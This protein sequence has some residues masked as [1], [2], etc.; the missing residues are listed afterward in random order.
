[1]ILTWIPN[2]TLRKNTRSIENSPN[3][4]HGT[5][6]KSSPRRTP[7]QEFS[8]PDNSVV[9][10]TTCMTDLSPL[11]S[12][13]S[14]CSD[15]GERNAQNAACKKMSID[16]TAD[17]LGSKEG[18][19]EG[20][21]PDDENVRK[22]SGTSNGSRFDSGVASVG[23]E[24]QNNEKSISNL[25]KE[26]H[27][28]QNVN[29]LY[30][31]KVSKINSQLKTLT[32]LALDEDSINCKPN[33][34]E[35]SNVS[36]SELKT[37]RKQRTSSSKSVSIEMDGDSLCITTE[38][39]DD[40]VLSNG[41]NINSEESDNTESR[42]DG[43][44]T[45]ANPPDVYSEQAFNNN[46]NNMENDKDSDRTGKASDWN[47][48]KQSSINDTDS[49]STETTSVKSPQTVPP[50][51]QSLDLCAVN[52]APVSAGLSGSNSMVTPDISVTRQRYSSGSSTTTSGPDSEPPS[53]YSSSPSSLQSEPVIYLDT[54][55]SPESF[56][57]NLQFPENAVTSKKSKEKKT[58]KEQVCGVFSVD[59]GKSV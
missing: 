4:S 13:V 5:T 6:P 20:L 36:E 15:A 35:E 34:S 37:I 7:R 19:S 43:S 9:T 30:V 52:M 22:F 33:S 39:L 18:S 47:Q 41:E 40:E 24:V 26:K 14:I 25:N 45:S 10:P 32:K 1:M 57:Q 12:C 17:S 38:E 46:L 29:D 27:V 23:E 58:A 51:P 31:D 44:N 50:H 59:L 28:G 56:S 54:P 16:S 21:T 2:S 53:P 11:D 42:Y 49:Q 48:F 8:K 55:S 3:R